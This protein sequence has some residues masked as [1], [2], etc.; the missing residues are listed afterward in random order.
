MW[1]KIWLAVGTIVVASMAQDAAATIYVIDPMH[2]YPSLEMP[3]MGMSIWRGKF[4]KSSGTVI[5]DAA[6]R[7]GSVPGTGTFSR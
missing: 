4:D 3:H 2:T 7:T 1:T 5:Y 6:A